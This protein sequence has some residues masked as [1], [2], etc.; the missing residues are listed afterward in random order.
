MVKQT[1]NSKLVIIDVIVLVN[2]IHDQY[3][4]TIK[5]VGILSL[6]NSD[7]YAFHVQLRIYVK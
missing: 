3:S 2:I 4:V 6:Y 5:R 1:Y 7:Q